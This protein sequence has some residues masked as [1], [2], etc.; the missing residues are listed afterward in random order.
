MQSLAGLGNGLVEG[1]ALS[2]GSLQLESGG[3]AGTVDTLRARDVSIPIKNWRS[4]WYTYSEGTSTPRAATVDLIEV[5][6][7]RENGFV[8]QGNVNE[9]MVGEGAHG[10]QSSGLLAT[11]GGTGGDE[12]TSVLAPEATGGPDRAGL[13]P[14]GLPLSGEVTVASGDTEKDGIVLQ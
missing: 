10:R 6:Q 7:E 13:V 4:K 1:F 9:T 14:E 11:A 5:G 3:L 2:L 12:E 8:A